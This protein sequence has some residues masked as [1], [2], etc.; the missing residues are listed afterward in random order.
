MKLTMTIG[1]MEDLNLF[2]SSIELVAVGSMISFIT[3]IY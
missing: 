2:E 1:S 3:L